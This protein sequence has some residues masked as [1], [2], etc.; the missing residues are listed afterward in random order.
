MV[1]VAVP[2]PIRERSDYLKRRAR[3]LFTV[4]IFSAACLFPLIDAMQS[5]WLNDF[6]THYRLIS[7][8]QGLSATMHAVG[9]MLSL[10]LIL[11]PW[12][13]L[14]KPVRLLLAISLMAAGFF[15][16]G[17]TPPFAVF[18]LLFLALG[19]AYAQMDSMS[20]SL[21]AD[22]Y[23]GPKAALRMCLLHAAIAFS[24][25]VWPMVVQFI[26]GRGLSWPAGMTVLGG[27]SC[28][29]LTA[30]TAVWLSSRRDLAAVIQPVCKLEL[31]DA[32]SL[33]DR[34]SILFLLCIIG[35]CSCRVCL[36]FWLVRYISFGLGSESLG[37]AAMSLLAFGTVLSRLGIPL[38]AIK[39][40][41]YMFFGL[42]G[43][44]LALSLAVA[45]RSP[46][47][48]CAGVFLSSLAG[49]AIVPISMNALCARH[50]QNTMLVSTT[51]LACVYIMQVVL[52][53]VIGGIC[54]AERLILGIVI[55]ACFS[56][57]GAIVAFIQLRLNA[58][59]E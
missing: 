34:R 26:R 41:R 59:P 25:I 12:F 37:P 5:V 22:L 40:E 36:N 10:G 58:R 9:K 7:A 17:T 27:I 21:T 23:A 52:P 3:P 35:T 38:L 14:P 33:F 53:L 54:G 46:V 8:W 49:G 29:C 50:R 15:L 11:V 18:C 32:R 42:C 39:V 4:G 2:F 6:I 31:S 55:A 51:V 24:G 43:E 47:V 30:Y 13:R 1:A 20:S 57:A 28:I 16:L 44:F 48:L 45:T 19:V 56:G